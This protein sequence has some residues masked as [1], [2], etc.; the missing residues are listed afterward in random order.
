MQSLLPYG[1][2]KETAFRCPAYDPSTMPAV[3]VGNEPLPRLSY[4][5][6]GFLH[7]YPGFLRP[8][9]KPSDLVTADHAL[10]LSM[11]MIE[12]PRSMAYAEDALFQTVRNGA[13][14]METSHG[15]YIGRAFFDG[16]VAMAPR[17]DSYAADPD[18]R[19]GGS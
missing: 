6:G 14:R 9:L 15:G 5:Q 3:G 17:L 2:L 12:N 13:K 7:P 19:K 8:S 4:R 16:H 11:D 1:G 10:R 18:W